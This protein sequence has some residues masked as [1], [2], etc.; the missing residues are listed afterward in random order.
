MAL[1]IEM[2]AVAEALAL[3]VKLGLEPQLL[4]KI[5][6]VSSSRC[7]SSDTYNPAPYLIFIK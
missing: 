7:W 6:N 1:G 3:G 4:S 2:V 5:M